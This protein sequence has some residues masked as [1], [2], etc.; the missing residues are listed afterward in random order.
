MTNGLTALKQSRDREGAVAREPASP[1]QQ[2]LT[3]VRGSVSAAA[4]LPAPNSIRQQPLHNCR[5]SL[6]VL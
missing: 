2:P 4:V 6:V 5:G 1:P 3:C